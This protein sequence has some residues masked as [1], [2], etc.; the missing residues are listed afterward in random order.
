MPHGNLKASNLFI[1]HSSAKESYK[2]RF[3]VT[4]PCYFTPNTLQAQPSAFYTPDNIAIAD[5]M[6]LLVCGL[7]I[8]FLPQGKALFHSKVKNSVYF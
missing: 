4:D 3:L 1:E 7:H 6:H 8:C 2:P 5:L